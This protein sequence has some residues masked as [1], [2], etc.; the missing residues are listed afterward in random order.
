MTEINAASRLEKVRLG[1]VLS[2]C[3]AWQGSLGYLRRA[4]VVLR[5]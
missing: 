4:Q 5:L 1:G 3:Q 2:L